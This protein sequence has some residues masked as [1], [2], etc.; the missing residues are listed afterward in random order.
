MNPVVFLHRLGKAAI[1]LPSD[2][3]ALEETL[4]KVRSDLIWSQH[5]LLRIVVLNRTQQG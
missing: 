5:G 4:T 3:E 2:R 1:Q